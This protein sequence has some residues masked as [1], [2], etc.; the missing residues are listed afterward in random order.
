[1]A[2]KTRDYNLDF[3]RIVIMLM[4][5]MGHLLTWGGGNRGCSSL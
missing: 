3:M 2:E 1:M 4:I 5:V